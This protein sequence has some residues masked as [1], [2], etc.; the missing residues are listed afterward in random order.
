MKKKLFIITMF[1][2]C[3][4]HLHSQNFTVPVTISSNSDNVLS[5]DNTDNSWQYLA[6]KRSGVRKLWMGL[7]SG[8]D[9]GFTKEGGGDFYFDGGNVGIGTTSPSSILEVRGDF[10]TFKEGSGINGVTIYPG[11]ANA[12]QIYSDYFSG[13]TGVDLVLGTYSNKTNQLYLKT[14]GN[15]GI[16]TT[17]PQAHFDMK[18]ATSSNTDILRFTDGNFKLGSFQSLSSTDGYGLFLAGRTEGGLL[19]VPALTLAGYANDFSADHEYDAAVSVRAYDI[20]DGSKLNNMP[21][22]RVMNGHADIHLSVE[23]NGNIGIGTTTPSEK[24]EVNGNALIQGDFESKKVK[25]TATPGSVPDYVFSKNY[26]LNTLEEVEQFI[27]TNSHLPDIPN[28]KEIETNGQNLG[29]MQL[30]LLEK[31]EELT[32]YV[33]DLKKEIEQLKSK[34]NE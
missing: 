17:S 28:A 1:C 10:M 26:T 13:G 23:A 18:K 11:A 33:I 14:D 15:V 29:E 24:L 16:G 6:F 3:I 21:V 9:F 32:L 5:F 20:T 34:D 30:K 19:P 31:I 2:F 7:D 4:N 25:V 8:N 27:N 12:Q 22:F